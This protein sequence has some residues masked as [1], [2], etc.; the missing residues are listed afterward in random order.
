MQPR[1]AE[2]L[3]QA[4]QALRRQPDSAEAWGRFAAVCDAH[5]LSEE[6]AHG[7][8]HARALA[9]NDFRWTYHLAIVWEF[10][11]AGPNDV[12][13]LWQTVTQLQPDYLPGYVRL[14]DAMVRY[15]RLTE[16]RDV[17]LEAIKRD[18]NFAM[19]HRSLGQVL[20]ALNDPATALRHLQRTAELTPDDSLVFAALAQ[21]YLRAGDRQRA[22]QA[23][24][25]SRRLPENL[26]LPDPI[27]IQVKA[28][29]IS[30]ELCYTR[31]KRLM[32]EGYFAGAIE[33]LKIVEAVR[34]QDPNVHHRLDMSYLQIGQ[35]DLG[36]AHLSK[37]VRLQDDLVTAH[38][39]LGTRLAT[40]RQLEPAIE[41]F[42][43]A[44]HHKPDYADAHFNLGVALEQLGHR[45]EAITH[46]RQAAQIDPNHR[47]VQ[48]LGQLGSAPR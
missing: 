24:E 8:R 23:A 26:G 42:R 14:A 15:G 37:A 21:A 5:S 41:H 6:A 4:R 36:I 45:A 22:D 27:R 12:V 34:P 33:N 35:E 29:G 38:L 40:R 18:P 13:P 20:L 17:Y 39:Q 1:V 3:G 43:R 47:A 2:R 48:R 7:Y 25:Q 11:G 46:Y 16:A 30:S 31:A 10:L 44:L 19:A 32:Q 28:L 9:P